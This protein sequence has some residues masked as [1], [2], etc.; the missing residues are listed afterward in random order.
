[1]TQK[2]KYIDVLVVSAILIWSIQI[3][4]FVHR[5]QNME[6]IDAIMV[7]IS[8]F[9]LFICFYIGTRVL[10]EKT[11]KQ[12]VSHIFINIIERKKNEIKEDQSSVVVTPAEEAID[13]AK[14]SLDAQFRYTMHYIGHLLDKEDR[15]ILKENL[16]LMAYENKI[17]LYKTPFRQISK[18]SFAEFDQKDINHLG[19]AIGN[20]TLMRRDIM[21]IAIF[22]KY[23]F[24]QVY[25]DC[26]LS[27]ITQKL[28][29]MEYSN[30]RRMKIPVADK[31]IPLPVFDE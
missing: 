19:H 3:Y 15:E 28:T 18:L 13:E 23:C 20:H 4:D 31:S 1:M 6:T 16:R 8:L 26:G 14:E 9:T 2:I 27:N 25:H 21:E 30:R 10:W 29:S 5:V 11:L 12:M 24:P 22:L 17:V 7:L